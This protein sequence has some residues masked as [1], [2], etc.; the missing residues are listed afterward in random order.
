MMLLCYPLLVLLMAVSATAS[1]IP[2]KLSGSSVS[3]FADTDERYPSIKDALHAL[4]RNVA[5]L[6]RNYEVDQIFRTKDLRQIVVGS[7]D[8]PCGKCGITF[9]KLQVLICFPQP[10]TFKIPFPRGRVASQQ[11]EG[12]PRSPSEE[13]DLRGFANSMAIIHKILL[14]NDTLDSQQS[15]RMKN[16]F[17]KCRAR[18]ILD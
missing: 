3:D 5:D 8:T 17:P 12:Q 14:Q 10:N 7:L 2:P 4:C 16:I 13:C 6:H 18:S 1:P 9:H 11:A 15:E